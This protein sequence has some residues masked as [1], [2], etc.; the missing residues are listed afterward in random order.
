M[1]F[2]RREILLG[3]PLFLD[4]SEFSLRKRL[5]LQTRSAE[6]ID[7]LHL[8]AIFGKLRPDSRHKNIAN[9]LF[10][11]DVFPLKTI[12]EFIDQRSFVYGKPT[13]F[14]KVLTFDVTTETWQSL[15]HLIVERASEKPFSSG[16]MRETY[17]VKLG[18]AN[19]NPLL[20]SF[21]VG[22]HIV[23][24]EYTT[25]VKERALEKGK[26]LRKMAMKVWATN[27]FGIFH[28]HAKC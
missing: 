14:Y 3:R 18:I 13:I 25:S 26:S 28:V 22:D 8:W 15:G 7:M 10:S 12:L 16:G 17:W 27:R 9:A 11:A 21:K 4:W 5:S 2:I 19:K 23:V 1:R 24:K 20:S 6:E